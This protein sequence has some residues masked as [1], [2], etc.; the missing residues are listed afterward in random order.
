MAQSIGNLS[1]KMTADIGD[2]QAKMQAAAASARGFAADARAQFSGIGASLAPG[3]VGGV[4]GLGTAAGAVAWIRS[5]MKEMGELGK[6]SQRLGVDMGTMA[7][8][9]K[10]A[11]G[12]AEGMQTA[13]GHL[14]VRMGE[15][16]AGSLEAGNI[17]TRM[18]LD[19]N[20]IAN[21]SVDQAFEKIAAQMRNMSVAQRAMVGKEIFGRGWQ[22]MMPLIAKSA[23]QM[24]KAKESAFAPGKSQVDDIRAA[25]AALKEM[26]EAWRKIG[27]SIAVAVAPMVKGLA[28]RISNLAPGASGGGMLD[29]ILGGAG[30]YANFLSKFNPIVRFWRDTFRMGKGSDQSGAAGETEKQLALAETLGK[31]KDAIADFEGHLRRQIETWGQSAEAAGLYDLKLKGIKDGQ[32]AVASSMVKQIEGLRERDKLQKEA[33][34]IHEQNKSP[35]DKFKETLSEIDKLRK[36]NLLSGDDAI[37]AKA[38]AVN[39]LERAV[40]RIDDRTSAGAAAVFGSQEAYSDMIHANDPS[41]ANAADRLA[42]LLQQANEQQRQIA[43]NTKDTAKALQNLNV[44]GN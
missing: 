37:M 20:Q 28:E 13:L 16:Q 9:T 19:P 2:F 17:F 43:E 42:E 30:D 44:A 7:A 31:Q 12:D 41:R 39:D 32:L 38:A 8:Y 36:A 29:K 35:L 3:L 26:D 33:D 5:S 25:N 23:E 10:L 14:A 21:L 1:A 40:G 22:E 11:G 4:G 15:I 6:A 24:Q 34:K 27:G 18:G